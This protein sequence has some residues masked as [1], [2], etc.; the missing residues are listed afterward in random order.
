MAV[1]DIKGILE[2]AA[3]KRLALQVRRTM[4]KLLLTLFV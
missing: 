1:D 2:A 4:G 3:L